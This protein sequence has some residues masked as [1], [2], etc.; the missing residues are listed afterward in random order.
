MDRRS[1]TDG[2]LCGRCGERRP[3]ATITTSGE[4]AFVC[5]RCLAA[6][7]GAR[8]PAIGQ[9]AAAVLKALLQPRESA[10]L[11]TL[12]SRDNAAACAGCGLTYADFESDGRA[13]CAACYAAFAPAIRHALTVL[14]NP[15][16]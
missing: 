11:T 16:Q 10:S 6:A 4:R 12:T 14:H 9:Q 5:D 1:E 13:G 15:G 7:I 3:L 8:N 2:R